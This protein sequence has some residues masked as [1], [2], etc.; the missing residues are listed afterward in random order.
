MQF[1]VSFP[2]I[3]DCHVINNK[4]HPNHSWLY[5]THCARFAAFKNKVQV[6]KITYEN[7]I[8][9]YPYLYLS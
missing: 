4:V 3:I 5:T 7:I 1:T 9:D 2:F 8:V 6:N